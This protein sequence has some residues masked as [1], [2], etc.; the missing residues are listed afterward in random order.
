MDFHFV[1]ELHGIYPKPESVGIKAETSENAGVHRGLRRFVTALSGELCRDVDSDQQARDRGIPREWRHECF[2]DSGKIKKSPEH[3]LSQAF[4]RIRRR[5]SVRRIYGDL[6]PVPSH[7]LELD[8]PVDQG[9]KGI[10]PAAP[11]VIARM[12]LGA[13]LTKDDVAGPD[14]FAAELFASQSLAV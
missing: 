10:V 3:P 13:V 12:D 9:E 2:T 6:F 8:Y 14:R 7:P 5:F 11:H 4:A 1:Y